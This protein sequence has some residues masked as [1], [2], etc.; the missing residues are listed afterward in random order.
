MTHYSNSPVHDSSLQDDWDD[1]APSYR[2]HSG[3]P[4]GIKKDKGKGRARASSDSA[5]ESGPSG[6]NN[7]NT[8]NT[9]DNTNAAMSN[10]NGYHGPPIDD[11]E[12]SLA[13]NSMFT[14]MQSFASAMLALERELKAAIDSLR[15][16]EKVVLLE[17]AK[18]KVQLKITAKQIAALRVA[19]SEHPDILASLRAYVEYHFVRV[20]IH[21]VGEADGLPWSE[22]R[23]PW[24]YGE[25]MPTK[26][27]KERRRQ[28]RAEYEGKR[29]VLRGQY[30]GGEWK[31]KLDGQGEMRQI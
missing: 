20:E 17:F 12:A 27:F 6:S 24:F 16:D 22:A 8:N 10:R 2:S 11:L 3:S 18:R 1:C 4:C 7:N 31:G 30:Y 26:Y 19:S 5:A 29:Q 14:A 15:A 28:L 23:V 13:S 25:R 9:N 21:R